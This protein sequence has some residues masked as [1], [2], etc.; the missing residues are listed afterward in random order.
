MA[1]AVKVHPLNQDVCGTLT[2]RRPAYRLPPLTA[3]CE[4]GLGAAFVRP[5]PHPFRRPAA[6][7]LVAVVI[8]RSPSREPVAFESG[9][10]QELLRDARGALVL[11]GDCAPSYRLA[12]SI[13]LSR[14]ISMILVETTPNLGEPWRILLRDRA[15]ASLVVLTQ[16]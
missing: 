3:V 8:D 10:L 6:G 13:A 15:P 16:N 12:V 9:V 4:C 14:R 5:A 2:G 11:T 1:A 7:P